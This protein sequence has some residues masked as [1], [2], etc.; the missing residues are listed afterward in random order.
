MISRFY[1]DKSAAFRMIHPSGTD[2]K[3]CT[4]EDSTYGDPQL[5]N[6]HSQAAHIGEVKFVHKDTKLA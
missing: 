3:V 6:Y 2:G 1:L 4:A 5:H